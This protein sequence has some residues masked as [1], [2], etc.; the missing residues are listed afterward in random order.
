[1]TEFDPAVTAHTTNSKDLLTNPRP[2]TIKIKGHDGTK[3][4]AEP[5]GSVYIKH[6]EQIIEL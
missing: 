3:T 6:K 4:K 1:M 2:T 5:I